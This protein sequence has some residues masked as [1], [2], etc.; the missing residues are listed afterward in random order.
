MATIFTVIGLGAFGRSAAM[1][2]QSL[3]N[4]V[5]GIDT[6]PKMVDE[7][8]NDIPHAMI[9]D[10]TSRD[11]LEEINVAQSQGV[12]VSIG[13]DLEASLLC[14]LN[15]KQ[16]GVTNIWVKAKSHAHHAILT[17][18]GVRR[19]IHPESSMGKR[20]A[21]KMNFPLMKDML[22]IA[23]DCVMTVMDMPVREEPLTVGDVL[24]MHESVRFFGLYRDGELYTN[25]AP[26]NELHAE[27]RLLFA[28]SQAA[29]RTLIK[30]F[31]G[32]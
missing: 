19:V 1:T 22:N 3:G 20:V 18:M 23:S 9:A 13:E 17:D 16:L 2:L 28:G 21:Q 15:L 12:L 32:K 11:M 10:A 30:E 5:I 26:E 7:I 27:D 14:V 29:L 8:K 25:L 24:N 4:T 6:D 31:R